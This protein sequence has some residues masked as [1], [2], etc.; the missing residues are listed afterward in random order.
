MLNYLS[1]L[2]VN[3]CVW[4]NT[5]GDL[6][7]SKRLFCSI[8]VFIDKLKMRA[9]CSVTATVGIRGMILYEL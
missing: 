6:V 7:A 9:K 3:I 5:E 8:T 4:V 2:S 1:M